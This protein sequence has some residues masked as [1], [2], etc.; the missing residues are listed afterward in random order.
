MSVEEAQAHWDPGRWPNFTVYEITCKCGC[1]Q[2]L[3]DETLMDDVQAIRD[4]L[5]HGLVISSGYRCPD[6]NDRVS[7]TGPNGPHT[8]G[9]VDLALL[10]G[11]ALQALGVALSRGVTGVGINQKGSGRFIHLDRL[12]NDDGCPRAWIWSY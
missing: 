8:K 5:G 11:E 1:N 12:E 6:H 7:R 9:A 2:V 4:E 10:G 3:I